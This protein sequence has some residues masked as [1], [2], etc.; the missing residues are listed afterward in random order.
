MGNL[1][2]SERPNMCNCDIVLNEFESQSHYCVHFW[3][4]MVWKGVKC[5]IHAPIIG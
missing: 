5:F 2:M 1:L 4:F 3:T